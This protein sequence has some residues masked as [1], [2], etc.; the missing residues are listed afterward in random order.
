M[1]C[2]IAQKYEHCHDIYDSFSNENG[3]SDK[4]KTIIIDLLA[5][6]PKLYP[7]QIRSHLN[8]NR[9]KLNI[10]DIGV[11]NRKLDLIRS[12]LKLLTDL[13]RGGEVWSKNYSKIYFIKLKTTFISIISNYFKNKLFNIF[14]HNLLNDRSII[15]RNNPN[16]NI[17]FDISLIPLSV[18][19]PEF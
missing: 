1:P 5:N 7:R 15:D 2:S 18:I 6:N 8:N 11:K 12:G 10:E 17:L 19:A 4:I 3:L 14:K 16:F 9:K 13:T